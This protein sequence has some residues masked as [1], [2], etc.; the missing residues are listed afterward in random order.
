MIGEVEDGPGVV[1][2]TEIFLAAGGD[3]IARDLTDEH[4]P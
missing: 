2:G 3:R 1:E 4:L